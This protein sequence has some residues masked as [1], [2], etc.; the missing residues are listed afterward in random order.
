MAVT[1]L[2]PW[3]RSRRLPVQ[4]V[5]AL[6]DRDPFLALHREMNRLFDDI[7][8][9][10]GFSPSPAYEQFGTPSVDMV[11]TDEDFRVSAELPGVDGKDVEVLL[12]EDNTLTIRGEKKIEDEDRE[13]RLRERFYGRFER[14]ISLPDEVE[15]D[16]VEASFKNGVL[17]VKL[18]RSAKAQENVRRIPL[19]AA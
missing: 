7:W 16:K 2:M 6:Q 10:F 19:Q 12:T 4:R 18:P 9:G 11:E 8:N 3:N 15:A 1:E 13:R 14:R 17:T 5:D